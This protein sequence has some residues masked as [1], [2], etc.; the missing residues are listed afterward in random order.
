MSKKILTFLMFTM[1]LLL[2][3][4]FFVLKVSIQPYGII[5]LFDSIIDSVTL[6][7]MIIE[8]LALKPP[9]KTMTEIK[10]LPNF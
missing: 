2:K 6:E 4:S 5:T 9:K 10:I 1:F 7:I 8:I 3:V